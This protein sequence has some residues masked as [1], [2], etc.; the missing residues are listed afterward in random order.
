MSFRYALS[1]PIQD[2]Y[3][4][5]NYDAFGPEG[6]KSIAELKNQA[7]LSD[8]EVA[9]AEKE[10]EAYKKMMEY[11][12]E[13]DLALQGPQQPSAFQ[14]AMNLAQTGLSIAGGL[15]DLGAFDGFGGGTEALGLNAMSGSGVDQASITPGIDKWKPTIP[16]LNPYADIG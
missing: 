12:T 10:A 9:K 7:M 4:G 2:F 16:A 13:A 5:T 3:V 11:R 1:A 15:K 6:L 14:R 8:A